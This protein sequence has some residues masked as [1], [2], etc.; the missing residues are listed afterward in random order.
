MPIP[1]PPDGRAFE[2]DKVT[3][4]HRTAT[5]STPLVYDEACALPNSWHYDD[6]AAPASVVLCNDTCSAIQADATSELSVQF[7]CLPVIAVPR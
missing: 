1:V 6:V 7:T 2:S 3:V 5:G 4:T